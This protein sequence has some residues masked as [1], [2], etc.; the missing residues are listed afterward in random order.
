MTLLSLAKESLGE[1]YR[2]ATLLMNKD[3]PNSIYI[4]ESENHLTLSEAILRLRHKIDQN[5]NMGTV[6]LIRRFILMKQ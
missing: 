6:K 1:I 3:C 4:A 2:G 5:L